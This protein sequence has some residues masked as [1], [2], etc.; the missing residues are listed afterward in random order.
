VSDGAAFETDEF[1]P[2]ELKEMRSENLR[3]AC[4]DLGVDDA[5]VERFDFPDRHTRE[6]TD[7]IAE[8]L[9]DMIARVDPDDLFIPSSYDAHPDH[10]AVYEA[11]TK[12]I[13]I[14]GTRAAVF[15][16]P[17]WFWARET[18]WNF[19]GESR[20]DRALHRVRILMAGLRLRPVKVNSSLFVEAKR[21]AM[22]NYSWELQPDREYFE[23]WSLG[24][25][26]L[27]FKYAP[28][29]RRRS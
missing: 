28:S 4:R 21:T 26:E 8:R 6:R 29:G 11:T 5:H 24:P 20:T 25:E 27:F 12:A 17:L 7:E 1:S 13:R 15:A 23:H 19:G 9:A 2:E 22:E 18:W 3:R 16:Y 10:Q 14:S